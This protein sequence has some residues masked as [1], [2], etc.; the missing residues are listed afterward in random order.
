MRQRNNIKKGD[1]IMGRVDRVMITFDGEEKAWDR[2]SALMYFNDMMNS[3]DG[4]MRERCA[5]IVKC[6]NA[7]D[8]EIFDEDGGLLND[9]DGE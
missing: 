3:S 4:D 1:L 2:Y 7:G 6:L 8:E 5:Y 9:R